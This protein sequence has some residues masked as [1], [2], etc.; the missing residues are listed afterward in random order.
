[1]DQRVPEKGL[2]GTEVAE[3]DHY[4]LFDEYDNRLMGGFTS[5][6]AAWRWFDLWGPVTCEHTGEEL[7][8]ATRYEL[9]LLQKKYPNMSD[10]V[11]VPKNRFKVLL[12]I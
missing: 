11:P 7:T 2:D 8:V 5:E 10:A 6:E 3:V 12:D 9:A 4:A 1:M